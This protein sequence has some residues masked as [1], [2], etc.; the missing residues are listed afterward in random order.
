MKI[1][2]LAQR[3]DRLRQTPP[4][5]LAEEAAAEAVRV[6][7][8]FGGQHAEEQLFLRHLEAEQPD[9]HVGLG[10]HVL[11]HVEHEAGLAHR[12][13]GR[14]DDQVGRLQPGRQL[15]EVGEARRHAGNQLL[16]RVQLLDGVEARLRE[17]AHRDEAVAD[18]VVG[19]R[20]DRVLGL[21][22]DDVG[23]V[24]GRVGGGQNP[25][26]GKDQAPQRRL[27]FD[28]ARV[29]LDVGRTRHAVHQR[30]D[31]GG[32]ADFVEIARSPELLLER[33]EIDRVAPLDQPDHLVEDA[34]M[35]V[36][37]KILRVD[38]F[39]GEVERVVVEQNRAEHRAFGLEIVRK[40][41]LGD[42]GIGH[43]WK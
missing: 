15:V 19:D 6:D 22:E 25:V 37:E 39:R 14:D 28:D 24:L 40:G 8:R 38:H 27:L 10:P 17:I 4:V 26:G 30:R 31:V 16:A 2:G 7:A 23:L 32:A 20:E 13:P 3:A 34:A 1:F 42:D 41:P 21:I 11:R 35:R 33:D 9:G 36:A 18:V 29:M 5:A 12:R 43:V